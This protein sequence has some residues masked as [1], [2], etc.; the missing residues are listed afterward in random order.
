ME[1]AATR[2][3]AVP[4]VG[5]RAGRGPARLLNWNISKLERNL[6]Q[7]LCFSI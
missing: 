6:N 5:M 3:K 7:W 4:T 2:K 1:E